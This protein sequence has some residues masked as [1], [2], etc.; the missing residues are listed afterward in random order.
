MTAL[1]P[2]L[3]YGGVP[4]SDTKQP[5]PVEVIRLLNSIIA[6]GGAESV[7]VDDY[8]ITASDA[9]Q[10]TVFNKAT[11]VTASLDP[12]ATVS[13]ALAA[14]TTFVTY[15][16]NAGAG[17]LTIDPSGS[18]TINGAATIE[19]G[20][21]E[22]A[23]LWTDGTSWRAD[24]GGGAGSASIARVA[25]RTA[26]KALSPSSG[27]VA[28]L[29]ESGREGTFIFDGSDLSTE[30]AA[31]TL[32]GVYVSS[33]DGSSGAWVRQLFL[34]F[35]T[36]EYFGGAADSDGTTGN[37]TDSQPAVDAAFDL[38]I[39]T[40]RFALLLGNGIYRFAASVSKIDSGVP[41]TVW[42]IGAAQT[43]LYGDFVGPGEGIIDLSN[44][45]GDSYSTRGHRISG[46]GFKGNG[47]PGDP[48]GLKMENAFEAVVDD[49][50]AP[51]G[52][53]HALAN[54]VLVVTNDN[55]SKWTNIRGQ[56]G[57]Q[58]AP[59]PAITTALVS[60]T[61]GSPVVTANSPVFEA[62]MAGK[63]MHFG[64]GSDTG[65]HAFW[66]ATI[67]S[68]DSTT[69]VTLNANA[70]STQNNV[71][72]GVGATVGSIT[73]GTNTLTLNYDVGADSDWIGMQ[74]HVFGASEKSDAENQPGILSTKITAAAGDMLTLSD[75]AT[76]NASSE[77]VLFCPNV[78][79]GSYEGDPAGRQTNHSWWRNLHNEGFQACGLL[80]NRAYYL[81][82]DNLKC[83]G[84]GATAPDFSLA[85]YP[86]VISEAKQ[87][88]LEGV[89]LA[90]CL[91]QGVRI[92]GSRGKVKM[93]DVDMSNLKKD[94]PYIL[95]ED[96]T[97]DFAFT[98]EN[99]LIA[100][101]LTGFAAGY[102]LI[103]APYL[104]SV[105]KAEIFERGGRAVSAVK[106]LG[107]FAGGITGQYR[108]ISMAD[109]SAFSFRP[110]GNFGVV[111]V[112]TQL[113][114][115]CGQVQYRTSESINGKLTN[116]IVGGANINGATT[117]LTGTTG[118]DGKFT[119]SVDDDGNI[120]LENRRGSA[121]FVSFCV[122]P[123]GD[124]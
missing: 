24:L 64:V 35:I 29:G 73:S 112:A 14:G 68:V 96:V 46:L 53:G 109:D 23:T 70:P 115:T 89:Q 41:M 94:A 100:Y 119:V 102:Q 75:N 8:T 116:V 43:F 27:D 113:S 86:L 20:Q 84:P 90:K 117:A 105:E 4:H 120:N 19:L 7:K 91:F 72:A 26:M 25:Y 30:V 103:S 12:A 55:N 21:Y 87:V 42:G 44:S 50:D 5:D 74:V 60:F 61:N 81:N 18:E 10:R 106:N 83:H 121:A 6:G 13:A 79:I 122:M 82:I 45:N 98:L 56:G 111:H 17:A 110:P 65:Q 97:N 63:G 22:G 40:G 59:F 37:G 33:G 124:G 88:N 51:F 32:E 104:E 39:A 99:G 52:G 1:S 95:I 76:V 2:Q 49:I 31:D 9:R 58:P 47:V 15:V 11:A 92:V 80:I 28:Y 123:F 108:R 66:S 16:F 54:S 118:A 3:V 69:Q 101:A 57:F 107:I 77:I 34:G 62:G 114:N 93:E 71:R 67:T 78:F 36:P 38:M 85:Y 48:I